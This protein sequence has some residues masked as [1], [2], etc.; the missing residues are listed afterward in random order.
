MADRSP[1]A[2]PAGNSEA[3]SA[4][5]EPTGAAGRPRAREAPPSRRRGR[6]R[7]ADGPATT[8]EAILDAALESVR[9]HGMRGLALREVARRLGVSLPTVQKHFP[10]RNDLWRACVDRITTERLTELEAL[11]AAVPG[12]GLTELLR[13]RLEEVPFTLGLTAAMWHDP[14]DGA[15]ERLDYLAEKATPVIEHSQRQIEALTAAGVVRPVDAGVVTALVALG[16]GSLANADEAL[17]R[18]F[19]IDLDDPAARERFVAAISDVL[20]NGLLVERQD[21]Q[22]RWAPAAG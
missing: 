14:E 10:T 21:R 13:R 16:L 15:Q 1:L 20:L 19:G 18:L 2:G 4:Q 5:R 3:E 11:P 12:A 17:R 7:R 6:P 8:A 9:N 22:R